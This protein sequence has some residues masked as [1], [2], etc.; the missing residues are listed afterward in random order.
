MSAEVVKTGGELERRRQRDRI[1][2]EKR[3]AED[4]RLKRETDEEN[5]ARIHGE[6]IADL[7]MFDGIDTATEIADA[8]MAGKVRNVRVEA[9]R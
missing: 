2:R 6:I 8:I 3:V 1:E 4:A 7:A 9:R 5:A